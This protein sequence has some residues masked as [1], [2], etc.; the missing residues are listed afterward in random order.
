MLGKSIQE[1][2]KIKTTIEAISVLFQLRNVIAHG[3][4]ISAYEHIIDRE[5]F[6]SEEYFFGGYKRAETLLL[7]EGIIASG[8]IKSS[9]PTIFFTDAV[10]DYFLEK[11]D[12]FLLGLDEFVSE[13]LVV[14]DFFEG[15]VNNFNKL[16]GTKFTPKEF[17]ENVTISIK[18]HK[19]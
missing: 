1:D 16:N 8:F 10:A 13:G 7:K 9:D 12:A 4:E 15:I 19:E 17:I 18:P 14:E 5:S 2:S 3:R 6:Q 11:T